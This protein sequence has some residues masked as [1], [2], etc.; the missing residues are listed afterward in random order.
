MRTSDIH[1]IALAICRGDFLQELQQQQRKK[2]RLKIFNIQIWFCSESKGVCL[3][4]EGQ[5]DTV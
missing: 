3:F 5:K 4:I 2:K 1:S